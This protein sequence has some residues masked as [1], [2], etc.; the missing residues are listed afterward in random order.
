VRRALG[1][2]TDD[3]RLAGDNGDDRLAGSDGTDNATGGLGRDQCAAET[4]NTCEAAF[5]SGA[6]AATLADPVQI[7][8]RSSYRLDWSVSAGAGVQLVEIYANDELVDYVV[9]NGRSRSGSSTV[10]VDKLP[11]EAKVY[12]FV[13]VTDANGEQTGSDAKT[14]N[15]PDQQLRPEPPTTALKLNQPTPIAA[16]VEKLTA[17][18]LKPREYRAEKVPAPAPEL[19]PEV[20]AQLRTDG[21]TGYVP[22]DMGV[23]YD[24]H[25]TPL[26]DQVDDLNAYYSDHQ[27]AGTPLISTVVVEGALD[28]AQVGPLGTIGQVAG[29]APAQKVAPKSQSNVPDAGTGPQRQRS[30]TPGPAQS[31]SPRAP[32]T[33][34][35]APPDQAAPKPTEQ[36]LGARAQAAPAAAQV[37]FWPKYGRFNVATYDRSYNRHALGCRPT[38]F[39][40]VCGIVTERVTEPKA[41]LQHQLVWTRESLALFA[42]RSDAYEHNLK[43]KS[44]GRTG[45]RPYC[46]PFSQDNFYI[47]AEKADFTIHNIPE[48]R[49]QSRARST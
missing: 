49:A 37:G 29:S 23:L 8:D 15:V 1:G 7:S 43:V 31:V 13:V 30:S 40:P 11:P 14:V 33:G 16:V 9:G 2:V 47:R 3:D 44:P 32:K 4:V 12:F 28:Q 39:G 18:G 46:N 17:A 26:V 42:E 45:I 35:V 34:R 25:S 10:A 48:W 24:P 41:E 38:L 22:T 5:V 27:I 19:D 21:A 20:A 6:R 36:S